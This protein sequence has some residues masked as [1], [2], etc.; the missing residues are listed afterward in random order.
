[1]IANTTVKVLR[2]F[3]VN[4]EGDEVEMVFLIAAGMP[5]GII[6]RRR[7]VPSEAVQDLR[8]Y[9]FATGRPVV[10]FEFQARDRILDERTGRT[11][12]IE[13]VAVLSGLDSATIQRLDLKIT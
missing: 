11:Y 5:M 8:T 13:D 1:M 6:E 3:E 10:A 7:V 2:G 9:H 12:Q 4:E